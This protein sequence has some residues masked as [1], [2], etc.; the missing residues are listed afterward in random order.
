M[1]DHRAEVLV[2]APAEQVFELFSH[3]NDYPKFMSHVREVT[4]YDDLRSHW[5][6]QIA[7]Q[8]EWDAVNEDWEPGRR[9]GWRSINGLKNEGAVFFEAVDPETTRVIVVLRYEPLGGGAFQVLGDMTEAL[10]AGGA[11]D[12]ALQRDLDNF[13]IM[14]E[15]A[16]VDSTD[17][18]WSTYIFHENSAAAKDQTTDR[19]DATMR[20][21]RGEIE[22]GS[23]A[24]DEDDPLVQ[25]SAEP[26]HEQADIRRQ[27]TM[28]P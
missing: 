23:A 26:Y 8:H 6:V 10:G 12:R 1:V 15:N 14:V 7:G 16:P 17:P 19:Q 25:K 3:F 13:K 24:V 9:I 11:V 18:N 20:V 28:T 21:E 4:Y 27:N 22:P 2:P 5:V